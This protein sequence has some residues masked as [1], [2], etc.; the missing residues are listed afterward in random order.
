VWFSDGVTPTGFT[1]KAGAPGQDLG[2]W[3]VLT[4]IPTTTISCDVW[5]GSDLLCW[6]NDNAAALTG[7]RYNLAANTFNH[8]QQQ[9][10]M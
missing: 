4:D 2:A 9:T 7:E 6:N 8:C 10:G 1:R 5:T 3:D